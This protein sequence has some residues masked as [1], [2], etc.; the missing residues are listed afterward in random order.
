MMEANTPVGVTLEAQE[1]NLIL[2]ILDEVSMPK[3]VTGP[4]A[5]K[6]MQEL[7]RATGEQLVPAPART[8]G[9]A[10]QDGMAA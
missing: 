2:H 3:R 10:H 1:W 5:A 9:A 4:L 7:Q 8:N 6:L